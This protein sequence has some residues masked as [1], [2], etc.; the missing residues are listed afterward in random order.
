MN[1][2][3]PDSVDKEE[4]IISYLGLRKT[5]GTVGVLLPIALMIAVILDSNLSLMPSISHSYYEESTHLV[6]VSALVIIG[7]FLGSYRGYPPQ[8]GEKISDRSL[9][10]I[11]AVGAVLTA[12]VPTDP[13]PNAARSFQGYVHFAAAGSFLLAIALLAYLK[14]AR[15]KTHRRFYKWMGGTI[16]VVLILI[17]LIMISGVGEK[18]EWPWLFWLETIAVWAFGASWLV[19]GKLLE[20][21]YGAKIMHWFKKVT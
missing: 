3:T 8:D 17:V 4:L 6:F 20:D 1:Q 14:F 21:Q 19:K 11:A 12:F 13:D 5:V 16:F 15:S 10:L 18:W 2:N 7:A 9:A